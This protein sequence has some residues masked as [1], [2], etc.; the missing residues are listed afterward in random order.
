[1]SDAQHPWFGG[2]DTLVD[3]SNI[4]LFGRPMWDIKLAD[5]D[6]R[7]SAYLGPEPPE[8]DEPTYPYPSYL[9]SNRFLVNQLLHEKA[10]LAKIFAFAY[11][12]EIYE[13]AKPAIFLVHGPGIPVEGPFVTGDREVFLRKVP[14]FTSRSGVVGQRGSFSHEILVWMYHRADFTLRLD[15]ESGSFD[16]LLLA[17]EMGGAIDIASMQG[18]DADAT[19]RRPRVRSRRRRW[20]NEDD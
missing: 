7:R 15:I 3:D 20:R 5:I 12:N 1:M 18:G 17:M 9:S 14:A 10:Q 2:F 8:G 19:R 16:N 13:L 11:Q 4:R 6:K